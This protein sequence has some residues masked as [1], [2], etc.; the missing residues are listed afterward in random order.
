MVLSFAAYAT[1]DCECGYSSS[2]GDSVNP[3]IFTDLIESDFLHIS[4]ITL[5][6]DWRRQQFN[7]SAAAGRGP[8]GMDYNIE[9]VVSNPILDEHSWS[10]NGEF[11]ADPGVQLTV[12]GG[13]PT[14]GF[15][16]TAEM[17]SA[18]EDLLWGTYRAAMKLTST[19]GTCSAFFWPRNRYGV[20]LSSQFNVENNTFPVN[21]VLQ[22]VQSVQA[23]Y[24]AV[25]T[26]NYVVA[27]LPFNPTTGYHE[28]RIDFI[29][30][31]VIF[32]ADGQI[33]AKMNSTAVPT[34]PGHMIITQ[35]SNGNPLWSSGPPS[36]DAVISVSYVKAYFN[37]SDPMR[38]TALKQRCKNSGAANAICAIPDQTLA[39]DPEA[40]NGNISAN[41]YFFS[42]QKNET[43]NQTVYKKSEATTETI[44]GF[45]GSILFSLLVS[46]I[47][48]MFL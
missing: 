45:P 41:T 28:Y 24:N 16:Q 20:F 46:M 8:Y 47:T 11:G 30:G 2:I 27:N 3:Y 34:S 1:A 19:P 37:S 12:G 40:T 29:P 23:G 31:N 7:V 9:Q 14:S 10:G 25:G 39:P 43:F 6:T 18:R 4:N 13:D 42:N 33:L 26:G 17:D 32:Y 38:E 35:W 15:V 44:T 22:S 5:D 21:L 36:H 48:I